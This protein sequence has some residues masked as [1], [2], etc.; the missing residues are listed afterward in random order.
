MKLGDYLFFCFLLF[1]E[2]LVIDY[3]PNCNKFK[4]IKPSDSF[5]VLTLKLKTVLVMLKEGGQAFT[6]K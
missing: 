2:E 6:P 3:S 5:Q 1:W 4:S